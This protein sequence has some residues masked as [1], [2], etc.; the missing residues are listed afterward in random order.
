MAAVPGPLAPGPDQLDA[1]AEQAAALGL[2]RLR[3]GGHRPVDLTPRSGQLLVLRFWSPDCD[4]STRDLDLLA[5]LQHSLGAAMRVVLV[6]STDDAARDAAWAA[7]HH[8][9]FPRAVYGPVSDALEAAAGLERQTEEGW[10]QISPVTAIFR[11]DGRLVQSYTGMRLWT[12]PLVEREMRGFL[13]Q[14]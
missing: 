6:S 7:Q 2:L 5:R 12:D 1:T 3:D 8:L 10:V 13:S 4:Y 9:A 14:P 11:H